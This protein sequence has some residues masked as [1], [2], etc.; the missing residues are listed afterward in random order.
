MTKSSTDLNADDI[1]FLYHKLV[2][3]DPEAVGV[4]VD[5]IQSLYN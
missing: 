5:A 2:S 3:V 4:P 1:N